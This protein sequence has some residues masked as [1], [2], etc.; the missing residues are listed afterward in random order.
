MD[1]CGLYCK[2]RPDLV[3]N[4]EG[5]TRVIDLKSTRDADPYNF[6]RAI[7]T[8]NYAGQLAFYMRGLDAVAPWDRSAAFIAVEKDPPVA[9]CYDLGPASLEIGKDEV[10]KALAAFVECEASQKWPG[11]PDGVLD[12]PAWRLRGGD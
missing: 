11:Y 10:K 6:S 2:A 12:L 9:V 8:Y 7:S 1:E 4:V 3:S 5:M